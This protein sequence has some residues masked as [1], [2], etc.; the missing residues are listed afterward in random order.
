MIYK[1]FNRAILYNKAIRV[2]NKKN[3][4]KLTEI[5]LNTLYSAVNL[6][7]EGKD[8]TTSSINQFLNRQNLRYSYLSIRDA[9]NTFLSLN[10]FVPSTIKDHS[11][12]VS[13]YGLSVLNSF[14]LTLR[15][16]RHDR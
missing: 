7:S 9:V 15:R 13:S 16:V 12:I 6:Q 1:A 4:L 2:Y 5:A 3:G 11:F 8:I 10:I 14:E